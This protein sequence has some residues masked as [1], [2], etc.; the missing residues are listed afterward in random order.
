MAN[1]WTIEYRRVLDYLDTRDDVTL[2]NLSYS[3]LSLGA[4][5]A[6]RICSNEDRVQSLILISGG[7]PPMREI[8]AQSGGTG[9][10]DRVTQ[11]TLMLN[12][13]Y[14]YIFPY[15]DNQKYLAQFIGTPPEHFKHVVYDAGHVPLPRN[16]MMRE[17][18]DWLDTY[19]PLGDSV[20]NGGAE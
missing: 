13:R 11:P 7:L 9:F 19:Q 3:G 4:Y 15:E 6:G 12:G 17:M 10:F 18:A 16:Q 1:E 14:D 2:E 5:L 8:V 20:S